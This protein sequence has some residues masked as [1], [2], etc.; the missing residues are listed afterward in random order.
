LNHVV[1]RYKR[2]VVAALVGVASVFVFI[3]VLA[4]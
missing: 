1:G 2:L 4:R 3:A